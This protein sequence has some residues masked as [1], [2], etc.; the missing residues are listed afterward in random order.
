MSLAASLA[1]S[2]TSLS[3]SSPFLHGTT[4]LHRL[5]KPTTSPVSKP[6][7][8][9]PQIRAKKQVEGK[10]VYD[11]TDKAVSVV[12]TRIAQ[13]PKYRHWRR[14]RTKFLVHDPE[15]RFKVGDT[16]FLQKCKPIS[17]KKHHLAVPIPPRTQKNLDPGDDYDA[18]LAELAKKAF[19]R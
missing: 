10:V 19:G 3:L 18:R 14:I 11:K 5:Q 16:V 9:L 15:N 6:P 4:P 1:S 8:L 12:V 7:A 13:V 17:K 2:F